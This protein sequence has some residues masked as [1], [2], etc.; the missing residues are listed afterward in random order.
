LIQP[1]L[2]A[3]LEGHNFSGLPHSW[4]LAIISVVVLLFALL[5]H[6]FG[7]ARTKKGIG[8]VDHIHYA[9]GL[10]QMYNWAEKRYFDPYNIGMFFVNIFAK[11]LWAVDRA[12]DWFYDKFCVWVATSLSL[13]LK[14]A[15]SGNYSA[16]V[17]WSLLGIL[18]V[19]T[20]IIV[21]I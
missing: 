5:N 12:I 16:S 1:I 11:A 2:G 7:V 14:K 18:I 10:H 15:F 13:I 8:A 3:R 19:I 20:T 17:S 21:L 4:T 6:M 9:P